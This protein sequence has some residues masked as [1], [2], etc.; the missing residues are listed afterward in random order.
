VYSED[1]ALLQWIHAAERRL[2]MWIDLDDYEPGS[3]LAI[4]SKEASSRPV[5]PR[6]A[7]TPVTVTKLVGLARVNIEQRPD[8]VPA[9]LWSPG[10]VVALTKS[11]EPV[12]NMGRVVWAPSQDPARSIKRYLKKH[13]GKKISPN[14]YRLESEEFL[15]S[16][17]D[18]VALSSS[19]AFARELLAGEGT[20]WWTDEQGVDRPGLV[21]ILFNPDGPAEVKHTVTVGNTVHIT[22]NWPQ[23]ESLTVLGLERDGLDGL[24]EILPPDP[25]HVA[26]R[27]N[28]VEPETIDWDALPAMV[29]S[30]RLTLSTYS[31]VIYPE[32]AL[33][34]GDI[35]CMVEIVINESGEPTSVSVDGCDEPFRSAAKAAFGTF[36]WVPHEVRGAPRTVRTRYGI[37]FRD[38]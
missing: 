35:D 26:D 11:D 34:S 22:T 19:E 31:P 12:L 9:A 17:P 5:A 21:E 2:E 33:G 37:R 36:R 4:R 24:M 27:L 23:D 28:R 6:P 25:A 20:P 8:L 15:V 14:L 1:Y 10:A 16:L 29:D 7:P 30:D 18:S 38:D 13:P 32:S 3:W